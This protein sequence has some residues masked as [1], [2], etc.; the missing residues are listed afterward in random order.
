MIPALAGLLGGGDGGAME[1][2]S[3]ALAGGAGGGVLTAV[4][5]IIKNAMAK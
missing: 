2:L 4:V 1:M 5:S 3:G